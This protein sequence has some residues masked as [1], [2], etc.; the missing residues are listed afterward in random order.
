MAKQLP[1]SK[2]GPSDQRKWKKVSSSFIDEIKHENGR[3]KVN[4]DGNTYEYADKSGKKYEALLNGNSKGKAFNRNVKRTG[5]GLRLTK[6]RK[7][8]RK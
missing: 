5:K 3:V 2:G 1:P 7:G 8:K 4:I 6:F